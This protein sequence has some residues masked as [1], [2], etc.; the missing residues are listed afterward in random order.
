M[1]AHLGIIDEEAIEGMSF[2][3]FEDVLSEL[4]HK[5]TFDAVANYAG[6][7]FCS[8]SWDMI[9]E[10]HPLLTQ[11][12]NRSAGKPTGALSDLAKFFGG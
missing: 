5:L 4:N 9:T 6:N 1:A 11:H 10:H 2:A 8:K 3:F 12:A 7:S